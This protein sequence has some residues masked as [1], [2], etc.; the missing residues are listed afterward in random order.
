MYPRI[1]VL[2]LGVILILVRVLGK[3]MLIRY[4]DP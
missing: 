4:L 3:Y 2:G 1:R